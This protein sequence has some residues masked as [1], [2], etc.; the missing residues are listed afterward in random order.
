MTIQNMPVLLNQKEVSK[1][2]RKSQAWL[3]RERWRGTGI[4]YRKIG[5]NVLYAESDVLSFLNECERVSVS[6]G[7]K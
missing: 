4:P 6:G 2:I 7:G 3:E 1:I 5:R